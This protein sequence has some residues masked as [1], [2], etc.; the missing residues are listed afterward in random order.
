LVENGFVINLGKKRGESQIRKVF[1]P[2]R[3][4]IIRFPIAQHR[5]SG[6]GCAQTGGKTLCP[7]SPGTIYDGRR[8]LDR[9]CEE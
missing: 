6:Y 8:R 9:K 3:S 7:A 4:A 5:Q 1:H 2:Q